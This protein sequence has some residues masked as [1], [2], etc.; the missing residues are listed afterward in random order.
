MQ[1]VSSP[2]DKWWLKDFPP[3]LIFAE[4]VNYLACD[5]DGEWFGFDMCPMKSD[6]AY[7]CNSIEFELFAIKM[8]KLTGEEWKHSLI[9]IDELAEFQTE[10]EK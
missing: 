5:K 6:Y 2:V 7:S 1:D 8:P 4:D 9:H 3:A 10:N